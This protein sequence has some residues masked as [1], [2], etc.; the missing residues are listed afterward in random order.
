VICCVLTCA[1]AVMY[2]CISDVS[3]QLGGLQQ[4]TPLHEA[5][6]KGHVYV[7]RA[8]IAAGA[9]VNAKGVRNVSF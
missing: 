1:N 5:A 3:V 7:V 4:Q 8:L 2:L 6:L 9:D